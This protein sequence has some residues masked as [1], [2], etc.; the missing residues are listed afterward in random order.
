MRGAG[1]CRVNAE[2]RDRSGSGTGAPTRG[3]RRGWPLR[4]YLAVLVALFVAAAVTSVWSG[5]V[6]AQR[7][8]LEAARRDAAHGARLAA[9]QLA[10][11][12][13]LV[14]GTVAQ[15]AANPQVARAFTTPTDCQLAFALDGVAGNGHLDIVGTSGRVVCSSRPVTADD[16]GYA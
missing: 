6:Q 13:A 7:D 16:R 14:R 10:E 2:A 11:A 3:V 9:Q 4:R 1:W 15:V 5:W 12:V 8:A